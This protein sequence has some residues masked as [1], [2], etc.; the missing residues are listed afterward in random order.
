MG[1]FGGDYAQIGFLRKVDLLDDDVCEHSFIL[2]AH[3]WGDKG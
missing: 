1:L 3:E 2:S